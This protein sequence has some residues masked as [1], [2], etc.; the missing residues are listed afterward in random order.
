MVGQSPLSIQISL[1]GIRYI[2]NVRTLSVDFEVVWA[3]DERTVADL[4]YSE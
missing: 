3:L 4:F 2:G 1:P